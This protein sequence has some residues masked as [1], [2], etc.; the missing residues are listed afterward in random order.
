MDVRW[1]RLLHGN[2]DWWQPEVTWRFIH[3]WI[4]KRV[5]P[6][7]MPRGY[8]EEKALTA[9]N[10]RQ[11]NQLWNEPVGPNLMELFP[12]HEP[13]SAEGLARLD[14]NPEFEATH[15]HL[16]PRIHS[17]R[18]INQAHRD[19]A[20]RF[21][22]NVAGNNYN[23]TPMYIHD[24]LLPL[25]HQRQLAVDRGE[26]QDD[27]PLAPNHELPPEE[28]EEPD[29]SLQPVPEG[30]EYNEERLR[31]EA[32]A[33]G[34]H[35]QAHIAAQAIAL[36]HRNVAITDDDG[37][38]IYSQLEGSRELTVYQEFQQPN[39]STHRRL[40]QSVE[41]VRIMARAGRIFLPRDTAQAPR[42]GRETDRGS[43]T[44]WRKR[45]TDI[46]RHIGNH[47][48]AGIPTANRSTR[49]DAWA[50]DT[51][52]VEIKCEP[53]QHKS[54]RNAIFHEGATVPGNLIRI[55]RMMIVDDLE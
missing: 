30:Q 31:A 8:D 24:L 1:N 15:N 9:V 55:K 25:R 43:V 50:N 28:D 23:Q 18:Y 3:Q 7:L 48:P 45:P 13:V 33:F 49:R 51:T 54:R 6:K 20:T 34:S 5:D 53:T 39:G 42:I 40:A 37:D 2:I 14:R 52:G 26:E 44:R 47:D 36:S 17:R 38:Q 16:R 10:F 35:T 46:R 29:D 32:A 27:E 11:D 19:Y 4:R 41:V 12:R 22:V 21:D